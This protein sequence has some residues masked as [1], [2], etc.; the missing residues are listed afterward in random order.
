MLTSTGYGLLVDVDAPLTAL[1]Q[2]EESGENDFVCNTLTSTET[3]TQN[4]IKIASVRSITS[5]V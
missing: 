2:G 3:S 1:A 4:V 5:V